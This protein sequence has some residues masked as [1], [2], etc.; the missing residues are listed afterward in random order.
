MNS[1]Q[2][3]ALYAEKFAKVFLEEKDHVPRVNM[4]VQDLSFTFD[5]AATSFNETNAPEKASTYKLAD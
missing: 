4:K 5:D 3:E 2:G 1:S